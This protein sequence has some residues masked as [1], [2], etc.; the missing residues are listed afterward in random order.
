MK[1]QA[2]FATWVALILPLSVAQAG[3]VY[4]DPDGGWSYLFTGEDADGDDFAALDGTWDHDNGSDAWDSSAIGEAGSAPGGVSALAEDGVNF[5]RFQDVGDPRD[6]G[7]ADPSNRKIYVTH[8]I[9]DDD[10]DGEL[11]L[12]GV[13]LTFRTRLATSGLLDGTVPVSGDGYYIRDGGKGGFGIRSPF[14]RNGEGAVVSF[15]LSTDNGDDEAINSPGGLLMNNLDPAG[16]TDVDTQGAGD[17]NELAWPTPRRGTSS[18]LRSAKATTSIC[19][20]W[21]STPT[22]RPRPSPL[23]SAEARGMTARSVRIW[24]WARTRLPR[25]ACSMSISLASSRESISQPPSAAYPVT[26]TRTVPSTSRILICRP[27]P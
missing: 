14:A 12:T 7:F 4:D 27:W 2:W 6:D 16:G 18:G 24:E 8:D 3:V 26:T 17:H 20:T 23:W 13:T 10:P 9:T 11:L 22:V 5:V 19:S 15:V 21:T 25:V 1:K